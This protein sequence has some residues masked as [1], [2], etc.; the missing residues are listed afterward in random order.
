LL[1]KNF[2]N[3]KSSPIR[4]KMINTVSGGINEDLDSGGSAELSPI[5]PK[6]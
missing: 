3:G 6:K 4:L 1:G 2:F 5:K